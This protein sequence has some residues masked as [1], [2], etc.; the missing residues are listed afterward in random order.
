MKSQFLIILFLILTS[1]IKAFA[2][3]G[4]FTSGNL[5]SGQISLM[6]NRQISIEEEDLRIT[7]Y[8][9]YAKVDVIYV[10]K[11]NDDTVTATLGFP[12]LLH[13]RSKESGTMQEIGEYTIAIQTEGLFGYGSSQKISAKYMY[14]GEQVKW[15]KM[16]DIFGNDYEEAPL[17][18][19]EIGWYVSNIDFK[20]NQN[21]KVTI[22]YISN[23]INYGWFVSDNTDTNDSQF[24]YLLSIGSTWKGPIKRGKV[25]IDKSNIQHNINILPAGRFIKKENTYTWEFKDLEPNGN[26][27]LLIT[28]NNGYSQMASYG[29]QEMTWYYSTDK[30]YYLS[31]KPEK[32]SASSTLK[33]YYPLN[34]FDKKFETAWVEEND[35]DGTGEFIEMKFN[36][37]QKLGIIGIIPGYNK[38]KELFYKNN[39]IAELEIYADD[40]LIKTVQINDGY[41]SFASYDLSAYYLIKLSD[42]NISCKNLKLKITKVYKGTDY[43]DACISELLLLQKLD[44]EPEAG[45]R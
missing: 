6:D 38:T 42:N 25:I 41:T 1:N 2:N 10:M 13:T 40:K 20:K 11:N 24:R 44:K 45:G 31:F 33:K 12:S 21:V 22:S 15:I 39:R 35:N 37:M 18:Y 34:L 4:S 7:L 36:K 14:K 43:N 29:S 16:P 28:I 3:G 17:E 8:R 5:A 19:P 32:I 9:G 30:K 27:N 23:Y 26:D